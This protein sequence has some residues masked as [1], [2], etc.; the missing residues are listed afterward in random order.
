MAAD[1]KAA[2]GGFVDPLR[3]PQVDGLRDWGNQ[4]AL[5]PKR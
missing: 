4:A 1:G 3:S 5:A 2:A